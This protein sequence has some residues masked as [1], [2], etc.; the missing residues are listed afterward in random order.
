[1]KMYSTAQYSGKKSKNYYKKPFIKTK[2][3]YILIVLILIITSFVYWSITKTETGQTEVDQKFTDQEMIPSLAAKVIST[4][5]NLE[6]KSAESDWVEITENYQITASDR[7]RTKDETKTVIELPDKSL[8]RLDSNTEILFIE[9]GLADIIIEQIQG[10]AFHRINDKSPAIY[11]VKNGK[12]ELTALGTAFNV[13]IKQNSTSLTVTE[14]RVKVKVYENDEI[15]SMRTIQ[16]GIHAIINPSL[17]IDKIIKSEEISAADL[18]TNNWY[19]WNLE[20]DENNNLYTGLFAEATKLVITEPTQSTFTTEED[21][22]MIKGVTDPDADIFI[23]GNEVTNSNGSFELDYKLSTGDNEITITVKKDKNLNK[24]ILNIKSTAEEKSISLN[25]ELTEL[26]A[27]IS[28][29]TEGL[30]EFEKFKVLMGKTKGVLTYPTEMYNTVEKDIFKDTWEDLGS[31]DYFFRICA[32]TSDDGCLVYSNQI[33]LTIK[34]EDE[35]DDSE[36]DQEDGPR[37]KTGTLN[38]QTLK[39]KDSITLNWTTN[40]EMD[41]TDGFVTLVS[42]NSTPTY[43]SI[44]SKIVRNTKIDTWNNLD[45]GTYYMRVCLLDG[46]TCVVYS[47]ITSTIIESNT[48]AV[49]ILSGSLDTTTINLNITPQNVPTGSSY[50]ILM[51]ESANVQFPA[52]ESKITT[53]N[54]YSWTNLQP[55]KTYYFRACLKE[56]SGCGSYSNEYSASIK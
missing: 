17:D 4:T 54:S 34:E 45:P 14:N 51:S 21:S 35:P 23:E 48:Q 46:D 8:I 55:G 20:Q 10:I 43:P 52:Q 22:V 36:K 50:Y 49:I 30:D 42:K 3:F 25:G 2:G 27:N 13:E 9:L 32:F 56:G 31:G 15:Q 19:A 37:E 33:H 47:N 40:E 26:T 53:A 44:S 24:K 18:L 28:W 7:I 11:R 1:M 16:E 12:T 5:G 38:L 41:I 39:N 6:L 29:T